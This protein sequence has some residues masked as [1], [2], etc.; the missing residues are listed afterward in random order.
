MSLR[1]GENRNKIQ[2]LAHCLRLHVDST[3]TEEHMSMKVMQLDTSLRQYK[4]ALIS[5]IDE[6]ERTGPEVQG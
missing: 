1:P 5:K 2:T 3:I 4:E 6:E